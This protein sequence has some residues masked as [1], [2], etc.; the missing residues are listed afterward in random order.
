MGAGLQIG[1]AARRIEDLDATPAAAE[2][3]NKI[4]QIVGTGGDIAV[5]VALH[6][7]DGPHGRS[8]NERAGIGDVASLNAL[9]VRIAVSLQPITMTLIQEHGQYSIQSPNNSYTKESFTTLRATA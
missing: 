4:N 5:T 6:R 3:P 8:R 1:A 9:C 2:F 7:H